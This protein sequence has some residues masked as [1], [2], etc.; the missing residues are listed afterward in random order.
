MISLGIHFIDRLGYFKL[1][2]WRQKYQHSPWKSQ[3][4]DRLFNADT[5]SINESMGDEDYDPE[6]L[7]N[8]RSTNKWSNSKRSGFTSLRSFFGM[9]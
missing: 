8:T 7:I 2:I 4:N 5:N 3:I 1:E 9:V 6:S